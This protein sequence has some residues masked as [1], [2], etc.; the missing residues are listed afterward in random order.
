MLTIAL[1]SKGFLSL[2]IPTPYS[3]QMA[4][5][6]ANCE[7]GNMLREYKFVDGCMS[8]PNGK[9]FKFDIFNNIFSEVV[10]LKQVIVHYYGVT[11][12]EV[13]SK[14]IFYL[15]LDECQLMSVRL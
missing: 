14:L 13:D 9:T 1:R 3:V 15:K 2:I 11:E 4:K 10:K 12:E 5:V 7:V 8:L 6:S